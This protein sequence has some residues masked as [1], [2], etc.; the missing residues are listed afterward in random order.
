MGDQIISLL[1]TILSGSGKL[2]LKGVIFV[3][4]DFPTLAEVQV[5]W[6]YIIGANVTD[7]DVTKTNTGRSFLLG[8]EI[9]WHGTNWVVIGDTALWGDDLT[10]LLPLNPRSV[11][12]ASSQIY[13]INDENIFTRNNPELNTSDTS[14]FGGINELDTRFYGGLQSP[15]GFPDIENSEIFYNPTGTPLVIDGTLTLP[16]RSIAVRPKLPA[17]SFIYYLRSVKYTVS[18][19]QIFDHPHLN[20]NYYFYVD[21]ANVFQFSTTKYDLLIDVPISYAKY[22]QAVS[23]GFANEERHS[24]TGI[25]QWHKQEHVRNG[26]YILDPATDFVI[27]DY[28]EKPVTPIDADNT[29]SLTAGTVADEDLHTWLPALAAGGLYTIFRKHAAGQWAWNKW[30]AFPFTNA[31]GGYIYY[32][33]LVTGNWTFVEGENNKYYNLWVTKNPSINGDTDFKSILIMPQQQ[34]D[35]LIS[36][37]AETIEHLNLTELEIQ[38]APFAYRI[39]FKTSSAYTTTG[40]VRI[41][42]AEQIKNGST[43]IVQAAVQEHNA[44]AGIQMAGPGVVD[45]HINNQSQI[46]DGAKEFIEKMTYATHPTI[47]AD[48]DIID[49]KY[50]DDNVPAPD[51]KLLNIS[52]D[53]Q[54]VFTLP[55]APLDNNGFD[56]YLNGQRRAEIKE[57]IVSGTTLTWLDPEGL[58]LKEIGDELIAR[59]NTVSAGSSKV[60]NLVT[61]TTSPYV[62][63]PTDDVVVANPTTG[64]INVVLPDSTV[65]P[66]R[67]LT[68]KRTTDGNYFV[69]LVGLIDGVYTNY[70]LIDQYDSIKLVSNGPTWLRTLLFTTRVLFI[71]ATYD[72]VRGYFSVQRIGQNDSAHFNFVMPQDYISTVD[73]LLVGICTAGAATT[74]RDIDLFSDHGNFFADTTYHAVAESDTATLY[75]FTG[76]TDKFV[77]LDLTKIYSAPRNAG[78]LIGVKVQHNSIG[79]NIDYLGIYHRYL[80]R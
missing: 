65:F 32:N 73:F 70:P 59:Y 18:S 21:S 6:M 16:A 33:K 79:G 48:V 10:D 40:K 24:S 1:D 17:T 22:S 41:E 28:E 27:G 51:K 13:K 11:N 46:I 76:K 25:P 34:H 43:R 67:E 15:T 71:P 31:P 78:D 49:K 69:V 55:T 39:V 44:L 52:S 45:G 8:Q 35:S 68:I 54:T 23:D 9:V 56:L 63:Q 75:D 36:A 74:S 61:T 26:A 57:Y 20:D 66:G 58:T 19:A 37:N 47:T 53:G 14:V 42:L 77:Q 7:N 64:N 50:F 30:V 3:A 5:G 38:E 80:R 62:I 4:A 12:V 29:F 72:N 2:I 60:L